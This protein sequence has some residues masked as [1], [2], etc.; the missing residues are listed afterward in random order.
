MTHV[1]LSVQDRLEIAEL[2]AR[3]CH[4]SDYAEYDDLVALF[5]PDVVTTLVG[6]GEYRGV[7]AQVRHARDT[8]T[9]TG[10]HV[11]HTVANLWTEPTAGGA[12]VHYYLAGMLRTGA[13]GGVSVNTTGRFVDHVVR[14]DAGWRINRR[15]FTM[16]H[17]QTPPDLAAPE[18][19]AGP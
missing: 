1:E 6:V 17:P 16:D 12:A 18:G 19:A 11:W 9:W 7:E 8:Q 13:E 2:P 4:H 15:E 14:T 5:T 10:G 3:F